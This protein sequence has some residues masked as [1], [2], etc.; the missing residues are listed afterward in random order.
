[1]RRGIGM[2]YA[3]F[4][5]AAI[6]RFASVDVSAE[7]TTV[8]QEEKTIATDRPAQIAKP[9]WDLDFSRSSVGV[10]SN[11]ASQ[12]TPTALIATHTI[13]GR[14]RG[15]SAIEQRNIRYAGEAVG[16]DGTLSALRTGNSGE[17]I[18]YLNHPFRVNKA[19]TIETWVFIYDTAQYFHGPLMGIANGPAYGHG[20]SVI[21]QKAK[22]STNGWLE[23]R[24]GTGIKSDV[25][26][27]K[28][29]APAMWHHVAITY[30]GSAVSLF[31]DGKLS[32]RNE[33]V[34]SFSDEANALEVN[35]NA[36]RL[37]PNSPPPLDFKTDKLCIYPAALS[38]SD[39]TSIY[40]NE[41]PEEK[42][43]QNAQQV[44][45]QLTAMRLTL[46]TQTS[47]YFRVGQPIPVLFDQTPLADELVIND[48]TYPVQM[49]LQAP[50]GTQPT[51]QFS[52]PGF[53]AIHLALHKDG[54]VIK[55]A[56]FPIAIVPFET[57]DSKI[58]ANEICETQPEVVSLGVRLG[59]V[60]ADWNRIENR[61]GEYDW[62][63]LDGIIK[64]NQTLHIETILC[65]TGRPRW[66]KCT[67]GSANVPQDMN[68]YR[69]L[70][71]MLTNRYD[72]ITLFEVWNADVP[73]HCLQGSFEQKLNDYTILLQAASEV[74]REEI[75]NAKILAGRIDLS[76]GLQLA[77][78]LNQSAAAYYDIFSV[79]K[80]S[81]VPFATGTSQRDIANDWASSILSAAGNPVWNTAGGVR[82]M[83][84][85]TLL[86]APEDGRS[87]MIQK[88]WPMLM[89]DEHTAADFLIRDLALQL[90]AGIEHVILQEGP[91][92]YGNTDS[93]A[94][95]LP[96]LQGQAL[97]VFNSLIRNDTIL[98]RV[99]G[100]ENNVAIIRFTP[101]NDTH[102]KKGAILFS[103]SGV[104]QIQLDQL[105]ATLANNKRLDLYGKTITPASTA[106]NKITLTETP[107]YFI[108]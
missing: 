19:F 60:I 35:C 5:F 92:L 55:Q 76:D 13:Y 57:T 80:F 6:V 73:P 39:I 11:H 51:L 56:D 23:L 104:Q 62:G 67:N 94:T 77:P 79:R 95:G 17:E 71:R 69:K 68:A 48:H 85:Q 97:A 58:G 99:Q 100:V 66:M 7:E 36:H 26:W 34:I 40:A 30:D 38:A 87:A 63:R 82:Q 102:E 64:R 28:G 54:S 41:K 22:W 8:A 27:H 52:E 47:G 21:F 93:V 96:S 72:G 103:L 81:D 83:P 50:A 101:Q 89:V 31:I 1:M 24:W 45:D 107:V 3:V 2:L 105:P 84:H 9:V 33:S 88:S 75:P 98:T 70:W 90:S 37:F 16:R 14:L 4:Y 86:P 44:E 106:D 108:E 10:L 43:V 46:P 78:A 59:R 29:F 53:H 42:D 20:M 65:F 15:D 74:I 12:Q 18:R 32:S 61:K 25:F 49:T 91:S